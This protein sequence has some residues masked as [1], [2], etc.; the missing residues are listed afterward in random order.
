[1]LNPLDYFN[2]TFK[3]YDTFIQESEN[4]QTQIVTK[5]SAMVYVLPNDSYNGAAT[6]NRIEAKV[7]TLNSDNERELY[8]TVYAPINITLNTFGLA[9]VNA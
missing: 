4:V 3:S 8:A 7:Y 6:N 5:N 1:M 9:S 2:S